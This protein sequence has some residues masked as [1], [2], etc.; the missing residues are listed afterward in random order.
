MSSQVILRILIVYLKQKELCKQ[1]LLSF[2]YITISQKSMSIKGIDP[3]ELHQ[4][5]VWPHVVG[6]IELNQCELNRCD[7]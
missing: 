7:R 5:L 2:F 6:Q 3:T 1:K 4:I